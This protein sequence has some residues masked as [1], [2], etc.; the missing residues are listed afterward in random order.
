MEAEVITELDP[1][2]LTT[3]LDAGRLVIASVSSQLRLPESEPTRTGG[4]LVLVTGHAGALVTFHDQAGHAP[5]AGVA[6]LPIPVFDRF[7]ARRGVALHLPTAGTAPSRHRRGSRARGE[8]RRRYQGCPSRYCPSQ[9]S[10]S[11]GGISTPAARCQR[12][13][14][15][16][17]GAD[18]R[19][20]SAICGVAGP[21]ALFLVTSA[22][23][24]PGRKP[25]TA[26]LGQSSA[27][28]SRRRTADAARR[29][30]F[31]GMNTASRS[32]VDLVASYATARAAPPTRK[33]SARAL[34]GPVPRTGRP[35][36]RGCP[37]ARGRRSCRSSA[38]SLTK[39]PRRRTRKATPPGRAGE[40]RAGQ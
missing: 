2:R 36:A 19:S 9:P 26:S 30:T 17:E 28:P 23:P 25:F 29:T 6:A 38:P 31:G 13:G 15:R 5:E 1:P 4:H 11:G 18:G 24:G 7:A 21:V 14:R 8:T 33:S 37:P 20:I 22:G 35:G 10:W 39:T 40:G 27:S 16:L 12:H 32:R 34:R 3:E